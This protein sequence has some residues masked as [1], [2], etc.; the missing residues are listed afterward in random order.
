MTTIKIPLVRGTSIDEIA[1]IDRLGPDLAMLWNCSD[2]ATDDEFV[3]MYKSDLYYRITNFGW[4]PEAAKD[5]I[6]A[7]EARAVTIGTGLEAATGEGQSPWCRT[8]GRRR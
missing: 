7:I 6:E 8:R 1:P 2:F 5:W 3:K 4:S